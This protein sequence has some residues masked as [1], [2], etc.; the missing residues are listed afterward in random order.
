MKKVFSIVLCVCLIAGLFPAAVLATDTAQFT[1]LIEDAWYAEYVD[2]CVDTGL[3][4][5][6]SKTRFAP[7][8]S[9][10]R[11]MAVTMLW[12]MEGCPVVNY[13]M[14]FQDV[15]EDAWY[16]EAVRW[17]AAEKIVNGYSARTFGTL[18]DITREDLATILYRYAESYG[19]GFYGSFMFLMPMDDFDQVSDWAK[20]P[21]RWCYMKDILRGRTDKLLVPKDNVKR[22]E[23][24]A[25]FMRFAELNCI[26]LGFSGLCVFAPIGYA[27]GEDEFDEYQVG[28]YCRGENELDFDVY[29]WT[30]DEGATVVSEAEAEAAEYAAPSEVK[31]GSVNGVDYAWYAVTEEDSGESYTTRTYIFDADNEFA[32]IVFWM[33][34]MNAEFI[35]E[36][37]VNSLGF[38]EKPVIVGEGGM[39]FWLPAGYRSAEDDFEEYQIAYYR[40]GD[41]EM[42]FDV[43][44]WEKEAGATAKSEAEAEAAEYG[45]AVVNAEVFRGI[46][47]AWYETSEEADGET[48]RTLTYIFDVDPMFVEMVFWMDG[49]EAQT[50]VD[51]IL[52]FFEVLSRPVELGTSGLSVYLPVGYKSGEDTMDEYQVAYYCRGAEETDF[53]VYQWAK[54]DGATAESEA[55]AEAAEIGATVSVG[56]YNGIDAAW[57]ETTEES[58]GESYTTLTVILDADDCFVELVFWMDGWVAEQ[59][60]DDVLNSLTVT[61]KAI[62]LGTSGLS[63]YLP[64]GY[65]P[66]EDTMD[67]YQIAYYCRSA[68]ETD[69]D[70][71]QWT[72]DEGATVKS[73]AEAEAAEFG[74]A[75]VSV[76]SFNGVDAAWYETT[77]ESDG[78]SYTTLTVILDA[79]DCFV[80]LVFWM[81]GV[82]AE[83]FVDGVLNSLT[84]VEK[85]IALGTSCLSITVPA[86]Y[87]PGEDTMDEYQVA[88]YCRGTDEA[89][90]DIYQWTKDEGATVKS[91][92][93]AEAAEFGGAAVSVGSFNGIDAAWYET[94]EESDGESYTTLTVILDAD[95]DFVELVFWMD[96][97]NAQA[98]VDGILNS[99]SK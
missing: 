77:E 26:N 68:E 38:V 33:D 71:Y 37:I 18:D 59:F 4:N 30:K 12:R 72:K 96:G 36:S 75:A 20:N 14:T 54:D 89:D 39:K 8:E 82:N 11:A 23:A 27:A 93:E 2:W 42:D 34:G 19:G 98:V 52:E 49:E 44:E 62:A 9:M 53:D 97:V 6:V 3:M 41:D 58:D 73:E 99:L 78:E 31:T 28:Y 87:K 5:G 48:Y 15:E 85:T 46:D 91:E 79:D 63:V 45:V 1:D 7:E 66:G 81:D 21:V 51:G 10:N 94:T 25:M 56:S 69:F 55:E 16:T 35:A 76:G 80:E 92:A 17:A 43:Y 50:L 90:F 64:V 65:E 57:Y 95:S 74:G 88:Y 70:V 67:E 29:E 86:G 61:E 60:V 13:A 40:R 47:I 24:A 84:V 32:E 83:Q 22:C